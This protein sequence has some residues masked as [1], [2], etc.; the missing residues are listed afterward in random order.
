VDLAGYRVYVGTKSRSYGNVTPIAK[1]K[2]TATV[3]NL[4]PAMTYYFAVT[5]YDNAG[6][7]SVF[8]DEVSKAIP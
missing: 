2:T 7:E 3:S 6:N 8:S 5:A 1:T 4:L